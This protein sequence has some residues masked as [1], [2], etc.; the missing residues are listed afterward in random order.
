MDA[1]VLVPCLSNDIVRANHHASEVLSTSAQFI[2]I[3]SL[4]EALEGER[5]KWYLKRLRPQLLSDVGLLAMV[6][7]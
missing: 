2:P 7:T 5:R 6:E 4:K 3:L 1:N